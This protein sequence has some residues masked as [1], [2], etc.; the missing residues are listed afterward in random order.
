MATAAS[1]PLRRRALTELLVPLGLA[2]A[3][4]LLFLLTDLDL[5][6]QRPLFRPDAPDP[7]P[8]A[9]QPPWHHLYHFACIPAALVGFGALGYLLRS[10]LRPGVHRWRPHALFLA[11]S[12][13]LGPAL[14]VN[15]VFKDHWGRPRPR[16]VQTLGGDLP[17]RPVWVK[18]NREEGK[19]FPCG[20]ASIGFYLSAFYFLFR[21]RRP[22]LAAASLAG[23]VAFGALV[24]YGRMA[25][26]AHFASDVLWA[27]LFV[28]FVQWTL[29]HAVLRIPDRE[30]RPTA[31]VRAASRLALAGVAVALAAIG[32]AALL[33][34]MPVNRRFALA[35]PARPPGATPVAAVEVRLRRADVQIAWATASNAVPLAFEAQAQGFGPPWSR[36]EGRLDLVKRAG[37]DAYRLR[38]EADGLFTDLEFGGTLTLGPTVR[39]VRLRAVRGSL[40]IADPPGPRPA[41][42]IRTR[43]AALR[44]PPP[45]HAA[46]RAVTNGP[47]DVTW[48]LAP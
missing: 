34:A 3:G 6:L 18:G 4:N 29:Y 12:L 47:N 2:A 45:L 43:G 15:G 46:A 22:A 25:A 33:F 36:V 10:A 37:A 9:G 32:V 41:F 1:H 5:R 14:V 28:W 8:L 24:G 11:L 17:F 20:H 35:A 31:P 39:E 27:A 40:A 44:L 21:R 23:A 30:D 19:S 16:R 13:A 42:L 7:W 26:G 38:A 48:T